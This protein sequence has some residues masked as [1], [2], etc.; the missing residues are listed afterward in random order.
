M[1]GKKS[2]R[3]WTAQTEKKTKETRSEYHK[4]REN[5][6]K[7]QRQIRNSFTTV[8]K[9]EK[10]KSSKTHCVSFCVHLCQIEN[11]LRYLFIVSDATLGKVARSLRE[12]KRKEKQ[13]LS[14][15]ISHKR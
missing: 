9:A 12:Q 10:R 11:A 5:G 4:W 14:K 7:N 8:T 15:E 3:E 13:N 1:N 2:V 6:G